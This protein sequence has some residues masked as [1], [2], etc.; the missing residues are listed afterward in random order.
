MPRPAS[1]QFTS[2]GVD[3]A[4]AAQGVAMDDLALEEVGHRG[5][6][7]VRVRSNVHARARSITAGPMW[8]R[9]MNGPTIRL[10]GREQPAHGEATEITRTGVDHQQDAVGL[11]LEGHGLPLR[12]GYDSIEE[13]P[14]MANEL[15]LKAE[16]KKGV[17]LLRTLRDEVKVK[18]HLAGMDAKDQWAK[19]EPE[20]FKV[21][22]A[23]EQATES[24]RSWWTRR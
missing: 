13:A 23:A 5:Q 10:R 15:D 1:I 7:D 17:D 22:R 18:L 11:L 2:P 16:M 3:G 6:R 21:E 9:K 19:L 14:A 4:L 12:G 24:S 8:S 20:L